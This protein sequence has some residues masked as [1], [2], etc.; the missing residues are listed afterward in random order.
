MLEAA[1]DK[2]SKVHLPIKLSKELIDAHNGEV[3]F[4]FKLILV[5]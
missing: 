1:R 3:C 2:G 4:F 5:Y